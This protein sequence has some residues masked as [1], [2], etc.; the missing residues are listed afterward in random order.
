MQHSVG[1]LKLT[2]REENITRLKFSLSLSR[3]PSSMEKN[4]DDYLI[5]ANT[6]SIESELLQRNYIIPQ[7]LSCVERKQPETL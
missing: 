1:I 3:R 2:K 6:S 7:T 4:E 5:A